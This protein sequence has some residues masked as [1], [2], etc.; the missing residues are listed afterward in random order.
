M[1]IKPIKTIKDYNF[2]INEI[3]NLWDAKKNTPEYDKLDILITLVEAYENKHFPI[4][5]PDPIEAIKSVMEQKNLKNVDLGDMIG[6]RS[7]ATE[8]LNKKRKLT[9]EMIRKINLNLGIPTEILIKDYKIIN[10]PIS[11]GKL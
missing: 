2:A 6:G 1:D 10:N 5:I 8:I 9:L 4:E 7:R 3:E 11:K